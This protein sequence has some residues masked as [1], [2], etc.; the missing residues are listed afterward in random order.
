M[1]RAPFSIT[2]RI[3]LRAVI[4]LLVLIGICEAMLIV[5]AVHP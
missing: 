5:Y 4:P 1:I 2:R 3:Y